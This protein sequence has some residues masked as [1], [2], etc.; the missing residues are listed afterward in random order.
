MIRLT[1]FW[2]RRCWVL[3]AAGI[4][5]NVRQNGQTRVLVS[6]HSDLSCSEDTRREEE[7]E[8]EG[9]GVLSVDEKGAGSSKVR[10]ITCAQE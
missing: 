7:V 3:S 1:I 10:N 8:E 4:C 6:V 2:R 9:V 5:E